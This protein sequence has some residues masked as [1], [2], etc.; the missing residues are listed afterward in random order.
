MRRPSSLLLSPKPVSSLA[1]PPASAAMARHDTSANLTTYWKTKL[2]AVLGGEHDPPPAHDP[3]LLE[4]SRQVVLSEQPVEVPPAE[5][6]MSKAHL[7]RAIAAQRHELT[8]AVD[9]RRDAGRPA[10][11]GARGNVKHVAPGDYTKLLR[12]EADMTKR[13]A[14][15]LSAPMVNLRPS[16]R[17]EQAAAGVTEFAA[18]NELFDKRDF[19]AA[20]AHYAAACEVPNSPLRVY[21][22]VNRGNAY[23]ALN[24]PG[25]AISCYQDALDEAPLDTPDGR[26]VH[27]FALSNL[28]AV[29]QDDLR[30]EQALQH[31]SAAVA[32][33]PKCAL[34]LKNRANVHMAYA[35]VCCGV[36]YVRRAASPATSR[37]PSTPRRARPHAPPLV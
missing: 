2:D 35:A 11:P 14:D 8:R 31:L 33:N 10:E 29:S 4:E 7:T 12:M 15:K 22:L 25:E 24:F 34:A 32:L 13:F 1:P 37:S 18:G 5:V 26:L 28:G 23:K 20:V 16:R 9:Q 19:L 3:G 17:V 6:R 36:Q 27:S 30:L 21:A